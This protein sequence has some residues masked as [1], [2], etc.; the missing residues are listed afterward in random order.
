MQNM[1]GG[2]DHFDMVSEA[3]SAYFMVIAMLRCS[4][5]SEPPARS[6]VLRDPTSP[7]REASLFNLPGTLFPAIF[8]PGIRSVFR[9]ARIGLGGGRVCAG[10]AVF[11]P[12]PRSMSAERRSCAHVSLSLD[13]DLAPAW[14]GSV[15]ERMSH[16]LRLTLL[17]YM[18]TNLQKEMNRVGAD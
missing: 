14:C 9:A 7:R 16:G 8:L 3:V 2:T 13:P 15:S 18:A 6:R 11:D 17:S 5:A 4:I 10:T 12:G 1:H